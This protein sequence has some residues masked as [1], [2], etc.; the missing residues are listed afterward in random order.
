MKILHVIPFFSPEFGGSSN[1]AHELTKNLAQIGYDVTILT[2]SYHFDRK[3]A[4]DA[5]GVNIIS[6]PYLFNWG[7][8]IYNPEI[9]NYLKKNLCFFDI[10]ILHNY[11]SYQNAML[12]KYAKIYSIP[13]CLDSHGMLLPMWDKLIL[14]RLFDFIWGNKILIGAARFIVANPEEQQQYVKI[15]IDS[16]KTSIIPRGID[17]SIYNTFITDNS[18]RKKYNI[19]AD[20]FLILF[21]GRIHPIKGLDLLINAFSRLTKTFKNTLLVIAG[22]D[23]GYLSTLQNIISQNNIEKKVLFTGH[24]YTDDKVM[25]FQ[26]ADLVVVPSYYESFGNVVIEVMA[27]KT[28]LLIS[29]KCS[30]LQMLT[31]EIVHVCECDK[32][33]LYDAMENLYLDETERKKYVNSA[34]DYVETHFSWDNVI[35]QYVVVFENIVNGQHND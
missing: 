23:E 30:I 24:L 22:P 17:I 33:K 13:Y 19:G 32:D 14:K 34:Y 3:Y 26:T 11:R 12:I 2:T 16:K 35:K 1:N 28:P 9:I 6:M 5:S 8:F 31:Q 27:S 18:F 29:N 20:T 15:G 7:L 25:A 10:I 4:N 21:L